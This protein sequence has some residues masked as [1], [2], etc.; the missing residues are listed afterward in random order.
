MR[1]LLQE[2]SYAVV[3]A[4]VT[5]TSLALAAG[6]AVATLTANLD[7]TANL[8]GLV[9]AELN[10]L[11][12]SAPVAGTLIDLYLVPALNG[13]NF[14]DV[15]TTTPYI[16]SIYLVSSFVVVFARTAT[17][18]LQLLGLAISPRLYKAYLWNRTAQQM[19]AG[20]TLDL[21]QEGGQYT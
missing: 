6:T 17:Q 15:D 11:F 10:T 13:T 12:T 3:N 5:G 21:Y 9:S 20:W 8:A 2:K 18:R 7:N 16:P 1:R 14:G 19:V 4:Q